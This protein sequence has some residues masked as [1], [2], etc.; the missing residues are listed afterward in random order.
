MEDKKHSDAN[1]IEEKGTHFR[2]LVTSEANR[3]LDAM[4]AEVNKDWDGGR[5]SKPQLASWAITRL[6]QKMSEQVLNDLRADHFDKIAYLEA[7][8]K[9]AKR[10]GQVPAELAKLTPEGTTFGKKGKTPKPD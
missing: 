9:K 3:I 5:I 7:L 6:A 4:I 2:V 8:L 1:L 10:T